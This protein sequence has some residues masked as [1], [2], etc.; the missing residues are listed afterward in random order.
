MASVVRGFLNDL[1]ER[2][3]RGAWR[4]I[5]KISLL[6]FR[7]SVKGQKYIG[8]VAKYLS[9]TSPKRLNCVRW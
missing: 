3:S 9:A 8:N 7:D 2:I 5:G 4:V 1:L 6:Y